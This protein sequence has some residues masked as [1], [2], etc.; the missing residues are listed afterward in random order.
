MI[1]DRR[2]ARS[3]LLLALA[4]AALTQARA[5]APPLPP[6]PPTA[7]APALPDL[8]PPAALPDGAPKHLQLIERNGL[9]KNVYW[10]ADDARQGRFTSSKAQLAT[11][12]YVA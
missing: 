3:L 11:A 8:G 12:K 1:E 6:A 7:T 5:Q 9:R 10:L 2:A 4:A